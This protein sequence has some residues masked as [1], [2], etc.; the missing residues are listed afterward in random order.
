MSALFRETTNSAVA[1]GDG[2]AMAYR[3]GARLR[4]LEFVQ[5]HPT[6][7]YIAGAARSLVTE[8]V[9]GEGAYLRDKLGERFMLEAHP[10]AELAP[11]DVVCR[12]I[13][14]RLAH[15]GG[16]CVYLDCRHLDPETVR[17]RFPSMARK[18]HNFG[19]D[20]TRDLI[21]V[22]PAAHYTVGG[23]LVDGDGATSVPY[24][25][26]AGEVASSGLHGA[27]RLGSNSLLEALVYGRAAGAA[28]AGQALSRVPGQVVP[29]TDPDDDGLHEA[30]DVRDLHTSLRFL[31]WRHVGVEREASGLTA[32]SGDLA[33]WE[34]YAQA[35]VFRHPEAWELQNQLLLGRL[36]VQ[37]ATRREETRGAHARRDF[38]EPWDEILHSVQWRAGDGGRHELVPE[39]G[40]ATG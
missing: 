35:A 19:L 26:G 7:L 20:L 18:V 23:V 15:T 10:Q 1:T 37:A 4:D 14:R 3:A 34:R 16:G 30:I 38:P 39:G 8:A 5:F 6:V 24:L 12:A 27:N 11:R 31:L 36:L 32:A 9:R 17:I 40:D 21:P 29:W 33:H 2:I 28:S 13:V 22:L 25:F